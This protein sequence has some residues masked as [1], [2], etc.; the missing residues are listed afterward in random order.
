[1]TISKAT[2]TTTR[3]SGVLVNKLASK[4]SCISY[5][6]IR[7]SSRVLREFILY[8]FPIYN[9]SMNDFFRF[10]P[11]LGFIEALV[12]QT[13]DEVERI[14]H[15][16]CESLQNSPWQAKQEMILAVLEEYNLKHCKVEFYM[17]KLGEYFELE[18]HLL[19]SSHVTHGMIKQAA[20]LRS[21][22]YRIL[23]C[24]LLKMLGLNYQQDELNEELRLMW[25]LEVLN[26]IEDDLMSYAEDVSAKQYNTYR[27]FVKVYGEKAP[28]YLKKELDFY[29]SLYHKQISRFSGMRREAFLKP[30]Q[31]YRLDHP[32]P[33]IPEPI[34]EE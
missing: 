20:E 12:Y 29:E 33:M 27:M 13:D 25:P 24:T 7:R 1:M 28:Y 19:A 14:Q 4:I 16:G 8:Y 21:S 26:D 10:Y 23:H 22:D 18:T 9:L 30:W 17:Q 31:A 5:Q 6:S 34:I 15:D 3:D 2:L 11:I 32:V